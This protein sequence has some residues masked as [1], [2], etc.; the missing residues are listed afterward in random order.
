[1]NFLFRVAILPKKLEEHKAKA[2]AS[3][4]LA[5]LDAA[6]KAGSVGGPAGLPE[7]YVVM[8]LPP[9]RPKW[10]WPAI[11]GGVLA[12]VAVVVALLVR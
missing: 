8:G 5:N 9:E 6:F 10:L 1:M 7:D 11:G 2:G 4:D 12:V 3:L